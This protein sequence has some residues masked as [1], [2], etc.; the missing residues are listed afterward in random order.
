[1]MDLDLFRRTIE[2]VSPLTELVCLHLMGDPLVHPQFPEIVDIC[3][4]YDANIFLVTNGVLMPDHLR[5]NLFDVLMHHRFHQINFSLHG[6]FDSF[7]DKDPNN[8][9]ERIFTF[10]E[11]AMKKRPN[12]YLNYRLWNLDNPLETHHVNAK[13]SNIDMLEPICRQFEFNLPSQL[14]VRRCKSVL[15]KGHLYLHFDTEFTW[16]DINLPVL[17]QVGSCYGL[18]SHFG[19]LVDGTLIPCCLDKKA[20][21]SLGNIR[22]QTIVD[23]LA[24]PRAQKMLQG[25]KEKQLLES[26]CQRCQYT[27]RFDKKTLINDPGD[28]YPRTQQ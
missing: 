18:S 16:T 17:G 4:Q 26:L 10:T 9:L 20:S 2:Q 22:E 5:K 11:H 8:Y 12:L 1:M 3:D 21:I 19:V 7:P 23:I 14:D 24:S 6:F 13:R 27:E 25:F 15:I 28:R